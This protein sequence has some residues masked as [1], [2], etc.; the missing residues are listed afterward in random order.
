M[1]QV[2]DGSW[3][4][5]CLG[6]RHHA[7]DDSNILGRETFLAPV[8]WTED[9]WPVVNGNGTIS[10]EFEAGSLPEHPWEEPPVR[11]E[12]DS[13]RLALCWNFL[14]NPYERDWSLTERKGFLRLKGSPVTLSD[15][16][17][18]AF[19]GRRQ[20]HFNFTARALLDFEPTEEGEEAGLCIMTR[21]TFHYEIA[22]TAKEGGRRI[23]VRRRVEDLSAVVYEQN[24][25]SG[26]VVLE[27]SGNSHSYEFSYSVNGAPIQQASKGATKLLSNE[28]AW[29][30]TGNYI[31]MYATGNGRYSKAPADFDWFE[32]IPAP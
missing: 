3:W 16:D 12:F 20:E 27:I 21:D 25:S 6:T 14:R 17:S 32:Y 5:V 2:H 1:F 22:V 8:T 19:I 23:I 15:V 26:A 13:N 29:I 28:L 24:I 9:G 11:D 30:F 7:Y 18:P 31:G 4:M 10:M